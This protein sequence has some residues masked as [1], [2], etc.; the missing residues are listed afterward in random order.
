MEKVHLLTGH[1]SL[2]TAYFI[3]T[4]TR[5]HRRKRKY[6]WVDTVPLKGDRMVTVTIDP[7]TGDLNQPQYTRFTAFIYLFF[8]SKRQVKHKAWAF[9]EHFQRDKKKFTEL[10]A[11]ID[12]DMITDTQQFNIRIAM[13]KSFLQQANYELSLRKGPLIEHYSAWMK[14]AL[15]HM[16]NSPFDQLANYPDLPPYKNPSAQVSS[17]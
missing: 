4:D 9:L 10:L 1:V 16:K 11:K 8:D 7:K 6:C 13:M 15:Q 14:S 17:D 2:E 3:G 5:D 12:Q